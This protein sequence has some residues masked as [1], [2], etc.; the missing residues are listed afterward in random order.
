MTVP[1]QPAGSSGSTPAS[2]AS[3][4][5]GAAAFTLAKDTVT[6]GTSVTGLA[7]VLAEYDAGEVAVAIAEAVRPHVSSASKKDD[8]CDIGEIYVINDLSALSDITTLE[9]LTSQASQLSEQ[10]TA[11]AAAVPD[12]QQ[13]VATDKKSFKTLLG[14]S[15]GDAISAL[16]TVASTVSQLLA[17]TYTYSGQAIPNASITG[18]DILIAQELTARTSAKVHVDRFTAVPGGS[19]ILGAIQSLAS[20]A[21]KELNLA[22]TRAAS[23]AA[24]KAQIVADD[25]DRLTEL[26]AEQTAA[27]KGSSP[28][29]GELEKE[30]DR[31][32]ER[33][34][35]ENDGAA[36]AQNT[37]TEGQALA[38]AVSTF[39][40]SAMSAPTSG[41]S[42]PAV[43]A[44]HGEMLSKAGTALLYGQV[45][46]AGDDQIL[47]QTVIHDTWSNLTGVTAEYALIQPGSGTLACG[48]KSA[49]AVSHGSVRKGLTDITRKPVILRTEN[50]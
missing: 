50:R 14:P 10:I 15:L 40:T 11:F 22:L 34:P 46:A 25:K 13:P 48:I 28:G 27:Q 5:S 44:S 23:A 24:E 35:G 7:A 20:L 39:I 26:D 32:C 33:L 9:I 36:A 47:R 6:S 29:P 17:G 16:G 18:L 43:H 1:A 3:S 12:R 31:I 49:F 45:I 21:A 2:S 37:L 30:Y 38:T 4:S 8:S 19:D 42:S 41:G